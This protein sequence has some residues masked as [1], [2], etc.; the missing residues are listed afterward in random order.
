V[1]TNSPIRQK[2][3]AW[4]RNELKCERSQWVGAWERL[5]NLS[6]SDEE[7]ATYIGRE[8][9]V[10]EAEEM[11][12]VGVDYSDSARKPQANTLEGNCIFRLFATRYNVPVVV[13]VA[14]PKNSGWS[15]FIYG[16][17]GRAVCKRILEAKD[18]QTHPL[19]LVDY[20]TV[21]NPKVSLSPL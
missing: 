10:K 20:Y 14:W 9:F 19:Q 5:G 12:K 17:D 16:K 7:L 13:Y 3:V 15:T 2:V 6:G 11:F 1:G 8:E 21:E 4:M 18:F